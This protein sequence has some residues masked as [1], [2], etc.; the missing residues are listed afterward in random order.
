[1]VIGNLVDVRARK[2]SRI[3]TSNL[4]SW[5]IVGNI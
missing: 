4:H 5:I 1:M 2:V 3:I